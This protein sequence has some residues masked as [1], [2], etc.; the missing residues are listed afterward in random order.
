[1]TTKDPAAEDALEAIDA[2]TDAGVPVPIVIGNGPGQY[3][4][5]VLVTGSDEGPPQTYTIH[6]PWSGETVTRTRDDLE[7]GKIDIAGSNQ[8]TAVEDPQLQSAE[9]ATK[10]T[11]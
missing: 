3:T 2:G 8:I 9:P 4:H 10:A 11:C 7:N 1:M 6:D 5:Y